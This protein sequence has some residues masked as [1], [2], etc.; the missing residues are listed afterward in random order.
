[1]PMVRCPGCS[2]QLDLPSIGTGNLSRCPNCGD[3]LP[4]DF[5]PTAQVI[6]NVDEAIQSASWQP[7]ASDEEN[8]FDF[9]RAGPAR[10][11]YDAQEFAEARALVRRPVIWLY[12]AC[13]TD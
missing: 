7:E 11:N 6:P 2:L 8:I 13:G 5:P 1:M 3:P 9:V 12:V 4:I 10:R